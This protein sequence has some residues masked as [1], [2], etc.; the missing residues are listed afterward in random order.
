MW[1]TSIVGALALMAAVVWIGVAI[2]V[3]QDMVFLAG[4]AAGL[5]PFLLTTVFV[6]RITQRRAEARWAQV[7]RLTLPDILHHL[8]DEERNDLTRGDL[9]PRALLAPEPG[10]AAPESALRESA[11]PSGRAH[12]LSHVPGIER[13]KRGPTTELALR[14]HRVHDAA[15]CR[16]PAFSPDGHEESNGCARSRPR[17]TAGRTPT[18]PE[19]ARATSS[20]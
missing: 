17:E 8:T 4:L 13:R 14:F 6:Y 18:A 16:R 2:S 15:G 7:M 3:W 5:A 11:R 20:A 10:A 19:G 12:R 1:I 9:A